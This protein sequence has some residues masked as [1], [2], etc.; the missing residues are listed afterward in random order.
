[1]KNDWIKIKKE[2]KEVNKR[3]WEK[4]KKKERNELKSKCDYKNRRIWNWNNKCE[5]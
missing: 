5:K 2:L 4:G 1:M 3:K